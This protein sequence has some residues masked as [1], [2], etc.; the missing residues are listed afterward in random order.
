MNTLEISI[1]KLDEH[2][3]RFEEIY[4]YLKVVRTAKVIGFQLQ[5]DPSVH[6][7]GKSKDWN[8]DEF[9]PQKL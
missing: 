8:G 3:R 5:P 4:D 2:D 9:D 6:P 7:S 1:P